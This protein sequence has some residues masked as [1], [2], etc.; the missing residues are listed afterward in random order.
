MIGGMVVAIDI[1][2]ALRYPEERFPYLY[3][4]TIPQQDIWGEAVCFDP[5]KMEGS[6]Y[7]AEGK[8]HLEGNLSSVAHSRCSKCL[9][10]AEY[11]VDV[12]FNEVF[13]Y[14]RDRVETDE[15]LPDDLDRLAYDGPQLAVDHLALTLAVLDMPIRFLCREDCKGIS[16]IAE[17]IKLFDT[18]QKE[19]KMQRP[20]SALQQLL[21]K[22]QEV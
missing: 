9:E 1:G 3:E 10:P 21:D 5:V 2:K 11:P 17:D 19:L 8:L 12:D 15:F 16:G 6:F 13:V 22:D 4:L 14:A 20:F 7:M 18:D